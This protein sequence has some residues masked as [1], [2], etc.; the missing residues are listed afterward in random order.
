[1]QKALSPG[2][3]NSSRSRASG[4]ARGA[5]RRV[6][7]TPRA[8]NS[9]PLFDALPS[10]LSKLRAGGAG[11]KKTREGSAD[12]SGSGGMSA[13][14]PPGGNLPYGRSPRAVSAT[15]R[16]VLYGTWAMVWQRSDQTRWYKD[17]EQR[18]IRVPRPDGSW[19]APNWK[20]RGMAESFL[21]G[22]RNA[23]LDFCIF[24]VTN[25]AGWEEGGWVLG[26][27]AH[28]V[29]Y[30]AG[31]GL[32]CTAALRIL[33]A[34]GSTYA[35][36]LAQAD[37]WA[38]L[39]A[40]DPVL[41]RTWLRAEDGRLLF[42]G[43]MPDRRSFDEGMTTPPIRELMQKYKVV[44]G[45]GFSDYN[46]YDGLRGPKLEVENLSSM[47]VTAN[48]RVKYVPRVLGPTLRHPDDQPFF[49]KSVSFLDYGFLLAN[50]KRPDYLVIGQY[51]DVQER[52]FWFPCDAAAADDWRQVRDPITAALA[53]TLLYDRVQLFVNTRRLYAPVPGGQVPDGPYF[54]NAPGA[55]L[56]LGGRADLDLDAGDARLR[57]HV[58][59]SWI[60]NVNYANAFIY[61][62][63]HTGNGRYRILEV[64]RGL[65]LEES[66]D[67][68]RVYA[69]RVRSLDS[70]LWDVQ[71]MPGAANRWRLQNALTG[72]FL[73]RNG[74]SP[75]AAVPVLDGSS[76]A[77]AWCICA[78]P[79]GFDPHCP[80][81]C[82]HA[83]I[84]A[85]A[86]PTAVAS[87]TRQGQS[88][89]G[90]APGMSSC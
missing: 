53:P 37:R 43:Y 59:S 67:D 50:E 71:A 32:R 48:S 87:R 74:A 46:G 27:G 6:C 40:S 2:V 86:L 38:A 15:G 7:G 3:P 84:S 35:T 42:V 63:Y 72:K 24:D 61:W 47:F 12:I 45:T 8:R 60:T 30:C 19:G 16:G 28:N 89:P 17:D 29:F 85:A 34:G 25:G 79:T 66:L 81:T 41:D 83:R 1:M 11:R 76:Q 9:T 21:R 44:W 77:A 26:D 56:W 33:Q 58:W 70:Q 5:P 18:G 68:D 64:Y 55:D 65:A 22:I 14:G 39:L 51:D 62:F 10:D 75:N 23:G 82:D 49:R 69:A 4:R 90:T 88:A 20:N 57:Q 36:M 13:G 78:R 31:I 73:G 52:G 54:F 80:E